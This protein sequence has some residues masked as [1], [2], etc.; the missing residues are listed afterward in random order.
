MTWSDAKRPASIS[1]PETE[2]L[3]S[4]ITV[5]PASMRKLSLFESKLP[6]SNLCKVRQPLSVSMGSDELVRRSC[7]A[8]P[9]VE[10]LRMARPPVCRRMDLKSRPILI[11]SALA[12]I[13]QPALGRAPMIRKPRIITGRKNGASI[14]SILMVNCCCRAFHQIQ[15]RTPLE[16]ATGREKKLKSKRN[17]AAASTKTMTSRLFTAIEDS[18]VLCRTV[19]EQSHRLGCVNALLK[20]LLQTSLGFGW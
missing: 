4:K 6:G 10:R 14:L 19:E 13:W 16:T 5:P 8:N 7:T 2:T 18:I 12:S 17:R 3:R 11:C 15:Q 9:S 20:L 1:F